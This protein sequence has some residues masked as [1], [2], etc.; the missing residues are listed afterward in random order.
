MKKTRKTLKS[1][2][3]FALATAMTASLAVL[4][5]Q[6]ADSVAFTMNPSKVSEWQGRATTTVKALDQWQD[7][8]GNYPTVAQ[9]AD[10]SGAEITF[11]AG[12]NR[13]ET[14]DL[15]HKAAG[16][17]G[18][19]IYQNASHAAK[20]EFDVNIPSNVTKNINFMSFTYTNFDENNGNGIY[21]MVSLSV[22]DDI[23]SGKTGL[24]VKTRSGWGWETTAIEEADTI[25][26]I[27]GWNH[28]KLLADY[29]NKKLI[30]YNGN[31]IVGIKSLN[32]DHPHFMF[33]ENSVISYFGFIGNGVT[34]ETTF[35]VK[36]FTI[37]NMD[38]AID[39]EITENMTSVSNKLHI[40]FKGEPMSQTALD[41]ASVKITDASGAQVSGASA[42]LVYNSDNTADMT[43]TGLQGLTQYTATVDVYTAAARAAQFSHTFT[44]AK[45]Y[46]DTAIAIDSNLSNWRNSGWGEVYNK[47]NLGAYVI[48][49]T[50]GIGIVTK[51]GKNST[52]WS[53]GLSIL[54][55]QGQDKKPF[56][57]K[58][59]LTEFDVTIPNNDLLVGQNFFI[60]RFCRK[61]PVADAQGE[62]TAIK[63]GIRNKNSKYELY[64]VDDEYGMV[65]KYATVATADTFA[66]L[67]G[68]H[69]IKFAVDTSKMVIATYAEDGSV[70][71]ITGIGD[72]SIDHDLRFYSDTQINNVSM[73]M[74]NTKGATDETIYFNNLSMK[75]LERGLT[76]TFKAECTSDKNVIKATFEEAVAQAALDNA[77][78]TVT[79]NGEAVSGAVV[80]AKSTGEKTAEFTIEGLSGQ[81]AYTLSID[82]VF[83]VSGRTSDGALSTSF[84]TSKVYADS[85]VLDGSNGTIWTNSYGIVQ[86]SNNVIYATNTENG[87]IVVHV[88][89]GTTP[90]WGSGKVLV[91]GG[92]RNVAIQ[93]KTTL[94]DFDLEIP[95][96]ETFALAN[97]YLELSIQGKRSDG[98][99]QNENGNI[100]VGLGKNNDKYQLYL[101]LYVDGDR[102][103]Y[104]TI[105]EAD[106]FDGI[107]GWHDVKFAIDTK[108]YMLAVYNENGTVAYRKN[109]DKINN[110]LKLSDSSVL[111]YAAIF[112]KNS[113]D[114]EKTIKYRNLVV[115]GLDRAFTADASTVAKSTQ[116]STTVTFDTPVNTADIE[117]FV[118]VA[119]KDGA[120]HAVSPVIAVTPVSETEA[121]ITVSKLSTNTAYTLTLDGLFNNDLRTSNGAL[122]SADVTT[123]KSDTV[124]IEGTPTVTKTASDFTA[125]VTYKNVSSVEQT[126][127]T[128]VALYKSNGQFVALECMDISLEAGESVSKLFAKTVDCSE[129]VKAKVFVWDDIDTI[130]ALQKHEL[131]SLD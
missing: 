122:V 3:S 55:Y 38:R 108:K 57:G 47:T 84:T 17:A 119:R 110:D 95:D 96:D 29:T 18:G 120:E 10:G 130:R 91:V 71:Y 50:N 125:N 14:V 124:F 87:E 111:N 123:T 23:T 60:I 28:I 34:E 62:Y 97:R 2:L 5:V 22:R 6:A 9:S 65:N 74:N 131:I 121:V 126:F 16:G 21:D 4:P 42:S 90:G 88:K 82:N 64:V 103:E 68:K 127:W 66:G 94:F 41:T 37:T 100:V 33:A 49:D 105:A 58:T 115:K 76:A 7:A 35:G 128:A 72:S 80:T 54:P 40:D 98:T 81:T 107:K 53:S 92:K 85:T 109:L 48:S 13:G 56:D 27:A 25:D 44:T 46:A 31:E 73:G 102:Y 52:N 32:K 118:T 12:Y 104:Y 99:N 93:S 63:V 19:A 101:R 116:F 117:K 43:I 24:Y 26:A 15:R 59:L 106:T 129:A 11:P 45:V 79:Q 69:H 1:I 39:T 77:A 51:A 70:N 112:P 83:T 89:A 86:N 75:T 8:N 61:N 30:I 113:A 36:N 20:F 114:T 67:V 78:Y